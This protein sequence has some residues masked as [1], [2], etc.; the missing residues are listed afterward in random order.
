MKHWTEISEVMGFG[1]G[2][3]GGDILDEGQNLQAASMFLR[4][5]ARE[6]KEAHE[7][8]LK[9]IRN[10]QPVK[11]FK[12]TDQLRDAANVVHN[13]LGWLKHYQ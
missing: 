4:D 13:T 9:R 2:D 1:P 3:Q 7:I 12:D 11:G 5:L 8:L 6:A 10:K